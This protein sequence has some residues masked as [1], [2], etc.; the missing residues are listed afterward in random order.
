MKEE[1]GSESRMSTSRMMNCN[2]RSS[3][4]T[5]IKLIVVSIMAVMYAMIYLSPSLRQSLLETNKVYKGDTDDMS[6]SGLNQLQH[7]HQ[8]NKSINAGN[9]MHYTWIGNQWVPPEGVPIYSVTKMHAVYERY[10]L[11]WIGDSTGRRAFYTLAGML[12]ALDPSDVS[13]SEIN[14]GGVID[15]GKN[16]IP[17]KNCTTANYFPSANDTDSTAAYSSRIV[18]C[19]TVGNSTRRDVYIHDAGICF[20]DVQKFLSTDMEYGNKTSQDYNVLV[21]GLGIWE[22]IRAWDCRRGRN[23]TD[24]GK[25]LQMALKSLSD[26]G[27][28]NFRIIWRSMGF[29][30]KSPDTK[31]TIHLYN[32]IAK[33]FIETQ[34]YMSFVD[35]GSE[36]ESRS[37]GS[38]KI[39]GDLAPHYGLEARTL[40]IN[41]LTHELASM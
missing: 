40:L 33:E 21:V 26:V 15:K 22:I 27:S 17:G 35:W 36:I 1:R 2:A 14:D 8:T 39:K 6:S 10:N 7:Q 9:M 11:A 31:D 37:F 30:T 38:S 19:G 41:M 28:P 12:N 25:R 4:C 3:N 13:V 24:A 32:Q 5:V 23:E 20:S 18:K 16:G 34:P 29:S